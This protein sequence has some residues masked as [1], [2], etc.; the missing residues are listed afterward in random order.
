MKKFLVILATAFSLMLA[1]TA[2]LVL[3]AH[4]ETI[5]VSG[6]SY[7]Y[8]PTYDPKNMNGIQENSILIMVELRELQ[9]RLIKG[10]FIAG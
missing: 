9:K 5:N 7:T 2:P 3:D 6:E 1:S 4:A 8:D 10:I